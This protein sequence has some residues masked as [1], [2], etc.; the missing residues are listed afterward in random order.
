MM[1]T[2]LD[3]TNDFNVACIGHAVGKQ[4]QWNL[5]YMEKAMLHL[6]ELQLYGRSNVLTS[7][8]W[9]MQC[10]SLGYMEEAMF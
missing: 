10:S 4:V 3:R 5:S 9:K 2:Q 7:V 6:M 8:I 1:K